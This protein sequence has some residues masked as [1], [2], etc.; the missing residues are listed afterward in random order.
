MVVKAGFV[1]HC[2]LVELLAITNQLVQ[3]LLCLETYVIFNT[4][5]F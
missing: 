2:N 3:V 4:C 1:D 5:V